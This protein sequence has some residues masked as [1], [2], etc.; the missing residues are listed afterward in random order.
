MLPRQAIIHPLAATPVVVGTSLFC[1]WNG[2]SFANSMPPTVSWV[3]MRRR[4]DGTISVLGIS[5]SL[6]EFEAGL[7][8]WL[9]VAPAGFLRDLRLTLCA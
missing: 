6:P 1:S 5:A 8:C 7:S 2:G 3:G 9:C 4:I